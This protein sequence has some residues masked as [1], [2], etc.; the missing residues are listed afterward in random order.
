MVYEGKK[1]S[2]IKPELCMD[3]YSGRG[4]GETLLLPTAS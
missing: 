1:K 4:V 2:E 3:G